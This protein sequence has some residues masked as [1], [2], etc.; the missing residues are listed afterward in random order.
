MA[1]GVKRTAVWQVDIVAQTGQTKH[2]IMLGLDNLMGTSN[3][4]ARKPANYEC[5]GLLNLHHGIK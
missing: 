2:G 5:S 4:W 1:G 3:V